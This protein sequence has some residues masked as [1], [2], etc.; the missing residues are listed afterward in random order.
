[1]LKVGGG[2]AAETEAGGAVGRSGHNKARTAHHR[3][4]GH[5]R[6]ISITGLISAQSNV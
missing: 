2:E 1:M 3:R 5:H 4:S 6:V